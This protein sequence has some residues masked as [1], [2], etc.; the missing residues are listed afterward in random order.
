[1]RYFL[2][3]ALAGYGGTLISTSTELV[4]LPYALVGAVALYA[5]LEHQDAYASAW[6][7][8]SLGFFFDVFSENPRGLWIATVVSLVLVI[9]YI[10]RTYVRLWHA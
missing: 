5:L 6:I 10:A 1:M 4:W 8:L 7:G 3:I 9:K 2:L